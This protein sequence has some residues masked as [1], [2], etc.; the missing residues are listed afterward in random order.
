MNELG[1]VR[2]NCSTNLEATMLPLRYDN[3]V[4]ETDSSI[5]ILYEISSTQ[6][7]PKGLN[8]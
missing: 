1:K 2:H 3:Y 8:I 6:C 4:G 5:R 7:V